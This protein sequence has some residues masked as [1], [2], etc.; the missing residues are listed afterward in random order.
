MGERTAKQDNIEPMVPETE[1]DVEG[2]DMGLLHPVGWDLAKA[3]QHEIARSAERRSLIAQ[4]KEKARN[5][6]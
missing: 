4:A 5:K 6:R 1:E 3:R 2:H